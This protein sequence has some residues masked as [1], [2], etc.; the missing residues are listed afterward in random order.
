MEENAS[1]R[2]LLL[3]SE[4]FARPG[5]N[6]AGQICGNT[7]RL[8]EANAHDHPVCPQSP[9]FFVHKKQSTAAEVMITDPT[10]R[11]IT[12]EVVT[13]ISEYG[14]VRAL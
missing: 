2:P 12:L 8:A 11:D 9:A 1:K 6:N 13:F 3:Y 14:D 7:I 5:V 10:P 4:S